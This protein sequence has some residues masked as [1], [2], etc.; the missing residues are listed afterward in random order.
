MYSEYT[1]VTVSTVLDVFTC[2]T[3]ITDWCSTTPPDED[4]DALLCPTGYMCEV[5]FPGDPEHEIPN[6]GRCIVDE[7]KQNELDEEGT[8]VVTVKQYLIYIF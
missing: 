3:C 2:I 4:E 5:D 6:R 8:V 1:Q 7:S